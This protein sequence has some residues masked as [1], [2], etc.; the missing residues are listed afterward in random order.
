MGPVKSVHSP[1]YGVIHIREVHFRQKR[2]R[3]TE[4]CP[5]KEV[6]Q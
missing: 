1:A 2:L 4:R 6:L 5:L 3:A